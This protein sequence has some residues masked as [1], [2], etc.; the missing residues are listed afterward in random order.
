MN[1][2][3]K[4]LRSLYNA[5]Y[6]SKESTKKSL[7]F[8]YSPLSLKI[9][10][11]LK[12]EGFLQDFKSEINFINVTLP[13]CMKVQNLKISKLTRPKYYKFKEIENSKE[14]SSNLGISVFSTS[15][16]VFT[17]SD[18]IQRRLG[19]LFLFQIL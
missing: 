15:Q 11:I 6:R 7:I 4:N 1:I 16:G 5:K 2:L 13:S 12:R 8:K 17:Y 9:C 10:H 18:L 14:F 19:G 3:F